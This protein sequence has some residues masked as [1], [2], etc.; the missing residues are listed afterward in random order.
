MSDNPWKSTSRFHPPADLMEPITGPSAWTREVLGESKAYLY[1]LSEAEIG[2]IFDAVERVEKAS[3]ELHEIRKKDF[4][5][6][7]DIL[8]VTPT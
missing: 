1:L 3:P 7:V 4:L 5:L 6:P 8:E 2:D